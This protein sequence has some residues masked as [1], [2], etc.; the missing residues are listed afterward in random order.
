[1]RQMINAG[2]KKVAIAA[3]ALATQIT[4]LTLSVHARDYGQYE[5]VP[6]HIRD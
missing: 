5:N 6:Q 2:Q 4:A 1:M 3:L